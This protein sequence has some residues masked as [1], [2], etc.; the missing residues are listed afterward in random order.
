MVL[1]CLLV[2]WLFQSELKVRRFSWMLEAHRAAPEVF[3]EHIAAQ[4][5]AQ[6]SIS[7]GEDIN[8]GTAT[9][10]HWMLRRFKRFLVS[11]R[12]WSFY[13]AYQTLTF[14]DV[15]E[16][17]S[18]YKCL[19]VFSKNKICLLNITVFWENS[20]WSFSFNFFYFRWCFLSTSDYGD[21]LIHACKL[22]FERCVD[23]CL[24]NIGASFFYK[25]L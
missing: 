8:T 5:T 16:R 4:A 15:I 2:K 1:V 19:F 24:W 18:T 10:V 11:I 21:I 14:L 13:G 25:A 3:T 23:I 20:E 6:Q 12:G 9:S 17:V 22:M 7:T